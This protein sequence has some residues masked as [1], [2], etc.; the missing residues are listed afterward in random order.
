[1]IE[2]FSSDYPLEMTNVYVL[3]RIRWQG[4]NWWLLKRLHRWDG[5][6]GGGKRGGKRGGKDVSPFLNNKP[7]YLRTV[8]IPFQF[9]SLLT[10][11]SHFACPYLQHDRLRVLTLTAP[12][13]IQIRKFLKINVPK[14]MDF[15]NFLIATRNSIKVMVFPVASLKMTTGSFSGA[16]RL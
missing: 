3:Q 16:N 10:H 6:E 14:G 11:I 12:H 13:A 9:F 1:M 2:I 4:P 15:M 7:S 5:S 8:K